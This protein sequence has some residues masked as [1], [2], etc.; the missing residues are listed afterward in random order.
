MSKNRLTTFLVLIVICLTM[1]TISCGDSENK[2]SWSAFTTSTFT[3]DDGL[4]SNIVTGI[5]Q[6]EQGILWVAGREGLTRFDGS[7][8]EIY[9]DILAN[10]YIK[11]VLRDK[12]GNLWFGTEEGA[13]RYT[14]EEL[15]SFTPSN[16]NNGLPGIAIIH[17]LG[18]DQGNI[19]FA[20]MGNIGQRTAPISYGIT[21]YNG[22]DWTSFLDRTL[23][24]HLQT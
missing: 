13:F 16:T 4:A 9:T 3:T 1:T 20:T 14:K 19:W 21:C 18:D 22:T 8:W 23:M 12:Q 15:Q 2:A 17:M 5:I 24:S 10:T 11:C 6:D 7:H